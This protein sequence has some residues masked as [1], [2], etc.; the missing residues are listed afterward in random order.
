MA[1][2][3]KVVKKKTSA[4]RTASAAGVEK[5]LNKRME[6]LE[7][8][9]TSLSSS[10]K[11]LVETLSKPETPPL[12][13]EPLPQQPEELTVKEDSLPALEAG[14]VYKFISPHQEFKALLKDSVR[15]PF[16]QYGN[17]GLTNPEIAD[18]GLE[19]DGPM[20]FY[21]TEDHEAVKRLREIIKTQVRMEIKEVT[22]DPAYAHI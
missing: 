1:E 10:V 17:Y 19:T 18:F 14:K 20:G 11:A 22:D 2:S 16:D 15:I 6:G 12:P 3:K 4:K 5:R 8:S 21:R 13:E 9:V 7:D